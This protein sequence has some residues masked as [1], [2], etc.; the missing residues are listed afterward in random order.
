MLVAYR[1][2]VD[3]PRGRHGYLSWIRLERT[4]GIYD[5]AHKPRARKYIVKIDLGKNWKES[6]REAWW[7]KR[8]KFDTFLEV[9]IDTILHETVHAFQPKR[10]LERKAE[11]EAQKFAEIG[12]WTRR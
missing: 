8:N 10:L 1:Y 11:A 9:L 4:Y 3:W 7:Q 5:K 12:R 6:E 2:R